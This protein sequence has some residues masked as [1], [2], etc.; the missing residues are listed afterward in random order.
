MI[1]PA[2]ATAALTTGWQQIGA[3]LAHKGYRLHAVNS[4]VFGFV[5]DY[6]DGERQYRQRVTGPEA[7]ARWYAGLARAA[8]EE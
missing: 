5:L 8:A 4:C 7:F 3:L 2:T 6:S 1:T